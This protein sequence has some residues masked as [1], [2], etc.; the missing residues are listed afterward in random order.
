MNNDIP[1]FYMDV[2]TYPCTDLDTGLRICFDK[3][4]LICQSVSFNL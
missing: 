1:L 2:I 3:V 4:W